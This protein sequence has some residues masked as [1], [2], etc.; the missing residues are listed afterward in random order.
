MAEGLLRH[1]AADRFEVHSAGSVATA[2]RPEAEAAM[3]EVGI[4][5]SGHQ[6]KTLDR[7][8]YEPFDLVVTVCDQARD[9]C[10][11]FPK[12]KDRLH[13]SIPDPSAAVGSEEDR[14]AAFRAVRIDL[15]RR[16]REEIVG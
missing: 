12:A 9:S 7:F 11:T 1:T 16:I 3:S 15:E 6:S 5:L 14:M 4:D 8:L 2:V 10:P 13:W